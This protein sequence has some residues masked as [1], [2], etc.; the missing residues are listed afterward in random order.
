M[1]E[2]RGDPW[3]QICLKLS[4]NALTCSEYSCC[5]IHT[6]TPAVI[7][8]VIKFSAMCQIFQTYFLW[9]FGG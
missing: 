3:T 4:A 1:V 5:E 9:G 7:K 8:M 6:A 2:I